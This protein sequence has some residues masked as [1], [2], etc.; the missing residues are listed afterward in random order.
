MKRYRIITADWGGGI[1]FSYSILS[2]WQSRRACVR[3]IIGR[4]G[5]WPP[6][7]FIST[8]DNDRYLRRLTNCD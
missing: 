1:R 2:E 4:W 3:Q 6:F 8:S 7:A 5:H